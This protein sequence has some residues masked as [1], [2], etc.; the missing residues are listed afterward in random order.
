MSKIT[1]DQID[2]LSASFDNLPK[3]EKPKEYSVM[4]AALKLKP[5]IKEAFKKNYSHEQIISMLN[6]VGINL[7]KE[8]LDELCQ[9]KSKKV[10]TASTTEV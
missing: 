8:Q 5:K 1:Q 10:S 2:N 9:P 6:K 7:T 3:L 4:E